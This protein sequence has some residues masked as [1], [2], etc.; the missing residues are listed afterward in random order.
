[1]AVREKAGS[2]AD[3]AVPFHCATPVMGE[4]PE[5]VKSPTATRR[6]FQTVR[7]RTGAL[8]PLPSVRHEAPFQAA[9]LLT[10]APPAVVNVPAAM[11]SPEKAASALTWPLVPVA[12]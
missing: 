5:A 11:T 3:H 10:A 8:R 9:T 6:E 2:T 12:R 4:A 1:M 7:A